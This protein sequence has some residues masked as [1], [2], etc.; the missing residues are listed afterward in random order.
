MF[1]WKTD[2]RCV[3]R[4]N[5]VGGTPA[6]PA[7]F[8][9]PWCFDSAVDVRH[10]MSCLRYVTFQPLNCF[11]SRIQMKGEQKVLVDNY[12]YDVENFKFVENI[13]CVISGHT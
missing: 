1:V 5:H 4:G 13:F 8:R 7:T 2:V 10:I 3:P 11:K 6:R 9:L 12:I